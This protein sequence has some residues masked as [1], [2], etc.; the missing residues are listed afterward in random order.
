M[1]PLSRVRGIALQCHVGSQALLVLEEFEW[2]V[3]AEKLGNRLGLWYLSVAE[4][5]MEEGEKNALRDQLM[6][7]NS[8]LLVESGGRAFTRNFSITYL[9][10]MTTL[11]CYFLNPTSG[12]F[13]SDGCTVTKDQ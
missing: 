2:I 5:V 1:D 12:R 7:D 3:P 13:T 6:P 4:E 8:S 11:G 9:L 10:K